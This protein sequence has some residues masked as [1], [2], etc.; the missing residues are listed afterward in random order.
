MESF[1]NYSK[2]ITPLNN[3]AA[4]DFTNAIKTLEVNK[5]ELILEQGKTCRNLYFI[6]SG[7]IKMFCYQNGKEFVMNFFKEGNAFT[8]LDS[9]N[10]GQPSDYSIVALED[11][12]LEYVSFNDLNILSDKYHGIEKFYRVLLTFALNKM[13]DRIR[14]MLIKSRSEHY[15]HFFENNKDLIQRLSL[16]DIACYLGITQ[17][18]L[19][20]IRSK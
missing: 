11:T 9:F 14:D 10:L 17:V 18:S 19:S 7:L 15:Q 13:M 6:N 8:V 1:L 12:R 16:G 4:K 2:S 20:R 5:G 3:L